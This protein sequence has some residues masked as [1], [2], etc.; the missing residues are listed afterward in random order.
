MSILFAVSDN[1]IDYILKELKY[2]DS[3][4][5]DLEKYRKASVKYRLNY[6]KNSVSTANIL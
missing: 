3:P 5:P 6:K 2:D 4:F 1:K